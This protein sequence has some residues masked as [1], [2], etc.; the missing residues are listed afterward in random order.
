MGVDRAN[1]AAS[2]ATGE[3][4]TVAKATEAIFFTTRCHLSPAKD[5]TG[6]GTISLRSDDRN[7]DSSTP[8]FKQIRSF[9]EKR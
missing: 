4:L 9:T 5:P 1:L 7:R 3:A 2:A 6:G 8:S